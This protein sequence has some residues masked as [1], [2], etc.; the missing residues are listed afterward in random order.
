MRHSS[1]CENHTSPE[2]YGRGENRDRVSDHLVRFGDWPSTRGCSSIEGPLRMHE[3]EHQRADHNRPA[4]VF[5]HA[6][7]QTAL[8]PRAKSNSSQSAGSMRSRQ[9]FRLPP[10]DADR[11]QAACP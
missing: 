5:Q 6:G 8:Q 2:I 4:S 9:G 10:T 3:A 11:V 7:G 1:A